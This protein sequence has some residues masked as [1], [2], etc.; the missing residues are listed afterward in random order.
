[1]PRQNERTPFLIEIMLESASGKRE[2]RISDISLGG[3][4][5]DTIMTV[6]PGED[7]SL[8]GKLETG[9][10][11]ELKGK[12]AYVMDGFGF[13]VSFTD[14][15]DESKVLVERMVGSKH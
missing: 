10:P 4:F 7:V 13:G 6:R 11:L 5:V 2:A 3:C 12:V 9:E 1:M 8:T 14:L 15:S